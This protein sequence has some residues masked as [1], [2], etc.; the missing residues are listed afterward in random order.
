MSL[1]LVK[2]ASVTEV[3][4]SFWTLVN[5]W[6]AKKSA[7]LTLKSVKGDLEV[8]FNVN[9]G[10]HD[11]K[12]E[13]RNQ[14]TQFLLKRG[15]SSSKQRRKQRRAADPA[16]KQ[17]AEAYAAAEASA[18]AAAEASAVEEDEIETLRNEKPHIK[19]PMVPSP[20]KEVSREELVDEPGGDGFC[21][22]V[23]IP[24]DFGTPDYDH[25]F[26]KTKEAEKILSQ[27]DRC[28]FC[29]FQCPL[30]TQQENGKRLFGI[31]ENLW[32]HIENEHPKGFDWLG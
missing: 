15:A 31:L 28:C 30:P 9:L 24:H 13:P 5:L 17:R 21:G 1:W 18:V 8:T 2:M 3:K 20:E 23:E 27:T 14:K 16:V 26:E 7:T 19:S 10:Q 4:R 11:G 25:D 29:A 32:D 6:K 12:D 22:F